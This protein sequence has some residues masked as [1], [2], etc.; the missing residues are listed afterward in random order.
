[1]KDSPL[2]FG[3]AFAR[4]GATEP[5]STASEGCI[6]LSLKDNHGLTERL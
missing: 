1:M 4:S 3:I 2:Y 5:Y 6:A